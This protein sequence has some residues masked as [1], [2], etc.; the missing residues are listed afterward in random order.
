MTLAHEVDNIVVRESRRV[1]PLI[2]IPAFW[3]FSASH[4]LHFS[5]VWNMSLVLRNLRQCVCDLF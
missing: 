2:G 4:T 3:Q 5:K 1:D